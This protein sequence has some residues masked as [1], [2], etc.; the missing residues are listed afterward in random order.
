MNADLLAAVLERADAAIIACDSEGAM[1]VSNAA[2]RELFG[3]EPPMHALIESTLRGVEVVMDALALNG[4]TVLVSAQPLFDKQ[5]NRM[6]AVATCA[7]LS[8]VV[9]AQ[10]REAEEAR[11]RLELLLESTG[12]GVYGID[13]EGKCVFVNGSAA[14]MLGHRREDL[15]AQE[16]HEIMHHTD[17]GGRPYP[18]EDCPIYRSFR[19]GR[20][21]R[22]DDELFFRADGSSFPAE[23]SSYP[24][25]DRGVVRGAVVTFSDITSRKRTEAALRKSE[26]KYRSLFETVSEGIYQTSPYGELLAANRALVE[27]LGYSSETEL[28]AQDVT[29]LY[30]DPE[31]RKRLTAVLERDGILVDAELQLKRKDGRVITVIENS[32]A[33]R[34]ERKRL[35]YYEG[36][37][38]LAR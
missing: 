36:T 12:E 15:I 1:V 30:V 38:S 16:M 24:I 8:G 2:A 3:A 11:K 26:A 9:E 37:L 29:D 13:T 33:I 34:D 21:C 6:G 32:R 19:E 31:D 23:Y 20:A 4:V 18:V 17:A 25:L 28:R 5:G 27:M 10:R 35:V 22:V 7:P 14:A